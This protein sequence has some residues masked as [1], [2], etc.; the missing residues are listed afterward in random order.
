MRPLCTAKAIKMSK[1]D[2]KVAKQARN[3]L[4]EDK[5]LHLSWLK[6]MTR[7]HVGQEGLDVRS[8]EEAHTIV[9]SHGLHDSEHLKENRAINT[10]YRSMEII[11]IT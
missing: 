3:T 8:V 4:G 6:E 9:A 10:T 5:L 2:E 11:I 7:R 1:Q